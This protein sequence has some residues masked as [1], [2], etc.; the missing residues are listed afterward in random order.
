MATHIKQADR[1]WRA[2]VLRSVGQPGKPLSPQVG[3]VNSNAWAWVRR[4]SRFNGPAPCSRDSFFVS[5]ERPNVRKA[6]ENGLAVAETV[7]LTGTRPP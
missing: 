2:A 5:E 1:A 3:Q 6:V 7:D 4:T